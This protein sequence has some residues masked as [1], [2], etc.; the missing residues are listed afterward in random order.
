MSEGTH[1]FDNEVARI[2]QEVGAGLLEVEQGE[3]SDDERRLVAGV[4]MTPRSRSAMI[5]E[6]GFEGDD[7]WATVR[8]IDTATG[9]PV[10]SRVVLDDSTDGE[11]EILADRTD[12]C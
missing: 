1:I 11:R 9:R 8:K 10:A 12:V 6:T 4:V 5:I 7:A 2:D 3:D